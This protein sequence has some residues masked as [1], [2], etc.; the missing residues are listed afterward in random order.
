MTDLIA[1]V[2]SKDKSWAHVARLIKEE[3]W[4][5]VIIITN[6]FGKKNF[7]ADKAVEFVTADFEKPVF[8][9]YPAI[10]AIKERLYEKGALFVSMSGSGSSVFGLFE[11]DVLSSFHFPENYLLRSVL[12]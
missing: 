6:D 1:C 5:R 2:S 9:K 12:L 7:K 8:E 3:D 11:K 10:N 4:N